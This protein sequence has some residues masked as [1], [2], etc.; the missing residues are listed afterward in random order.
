MGGKG[1]IFLVLGFSLIFM[2]VGRNFNSMATATVDNFTAY[3]YE[4]K[5]H[6]IAATGVNLVTNQIFL[7]GALPDQTFNYSFDG[8]TVTATLTT[9]DA[10]QNIKEL[11]SVGTYAGVSSS[12]R[13]ILKPSVFSKYAYFSDTESADIW[14]T[15]AD[16]VWGPM[17]TNGNLRVADRPV[18]MGKVTIDG[19]LVKY[20]NSARPQFLG[21]FQTGVHIDIPSNGVSNLATAATAGGAKFTGR[22]LV[23]LEFRGDSIRYKFSSSGA[24]TYRLASTFAPNGTI[25]A[26]NAELRIKGRVSGRYTIGASGTGS[27]RGKI[28]LDDDVYYNTDPQVNPNSQDML[29]IVAQRDVIITE[30]SANNNNIKIQ[31]SIYCQEGSFS[32]EDYQSRPVSGAIQLYGGLIQD[33]RGPVGTFRTVH[34]QSVIQS[35]FSKRYRYDDRFMVASPPF[36]PGT[37]SFEIVSWFE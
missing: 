12:V 3:Y 31:A 23:Y 14:W 21:G 19:R 9:I 37:N 24:W 1:A 22:S 15:T 27:N 18:F 20:S 28:F 10:F 36:F 11:T 32:A 6:H 16:T 8:G 7:N 17:H 13:I 5:V 30:N 35:G 4:T 29:G 33:T 25:F 2:V 26:E 34:G